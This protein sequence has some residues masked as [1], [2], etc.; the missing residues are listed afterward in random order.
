MENPDDQND[1]GK[2]KEDSLGEWID[3]AKRAHELVD[4]VDFDKVTEHDVTEVSKVETVTNALSDLA[5]GRDVEHVEGVDE[6]DASVSKEQERI[7]K[8]FTD[9]ADAGWTERMGRVLCVDGG[10]RI[11]KPLEL[12][13]HRQGLPE[14][15]V[16]I[17]PENRLN[18]GNYG[19]FISASGI[20]AASIHEPVNKYHWRIDRSSPYETQ[21]E[22]IRT[23]KKFSEKDD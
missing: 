14:F 11:P 3:R 9:I 7:A 10:E 8:L 22:L 12:I 17:A 21:T 1:D 4:A 6:V 15:D 18:S 20:F 23:I 16:C 13:S 5:A 19:I 2:A